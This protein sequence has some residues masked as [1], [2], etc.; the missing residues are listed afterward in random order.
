M[1][2]KSTYMFAAYINL[3]IMKQLSYIYYLIQNNNIHTLM[4]TIHW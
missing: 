1:M 4:T 3:S 2:L